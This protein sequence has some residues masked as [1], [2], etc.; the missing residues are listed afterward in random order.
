[1]IAEPKY[2]VK[3]L[4]TEHR[5][6]MK[7]D[8]GKILISKL[9]KKDCGFTLVELLVVVIII[10]ILSAIS[11]PAYLSLTASSK[12]SEAR[13]NLSSIM[14]AQQLWMDERA[15]D[16]YPPNLD[17]LALGVVKGSGLQDSTTS[18]VYT[19]SIANGTPGNY[20]LSAG[21]LPKDPKLKTYTGAVRSFSNSA[22]NS[23]W[24][25]VTCE[26]IATDEAISYPEPSGSGSASTL[27]CNSNYNRL[28]VTGR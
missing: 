24:Y 20:Q 28:S 2:W 18:T 9:L 1:M 4:Y 27:T 26:S 15:S 8:A 22:G 23:T 17:I 14:H 3:S 5:S 6:N 25:S 13:Q 7:V 16:S 21:A 12:Q 10:G 11:L 19:Y